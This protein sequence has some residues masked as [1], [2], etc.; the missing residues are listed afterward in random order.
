[1]RAVVVIG[2][3]LFAGCRGPRAPAPSERSAIGPPVALEVELGGCATIRG[4]GACVRS[5]SSA[6]SELR[7]WIRTRDTARLEVSL[8][9]AI[10]AVGPPER[11][12]GGRRLRI[13]APIEARQLSLVVRDG[14]RSARW[15]RRL[16]V[17]ASCP[18][19]D[20]AFDVGRRQRRPDEGFARLDAA[21]SRSDL[22]TGCRARAAGVRA[23]LFLDRDDPTSA[24]ASFRR[25]VELS[26]GES[27]DDAFAS[28]FVL[29][30]KVRDFE[31]A[32][33][34]LDA[35]E[36]R[37]GQ[38]ASGRVLHAYFRGLLARESGDLRSA[39][40][41]LSTS[42]AGA[43]RIGRT[44]TYLDA[45]QMSA[46]VLSSI[47]R[48]DEALDRLG[49]LDRLVADHPDVDDCAR[50]RLWA[51]VGWN[52]A[53]DRVARAA[54]G[55]PPGAD[56]GPPLRRSIAL[57]QGA[58]P[59]RA[60]QSNALVNLAVVAMIEGQLDAAEAALAR[61]RDVDPQPD[62]FVELWSRDLEG[63]I[64][65]GR[66]RHEEA[67]RVYAA[68][69]DDA[70]PRPRHGG[71]PTWAMPARSSGCRELPRRW[72]RTERPRISRRS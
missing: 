46:A 40:R 63:R 32:A 22:S 41:W 3:A 65:A 28:A 48:T 72:W 69:V 57:R 27:L 68:L 2:L 26:D 18:D 33:S 5:E 51:N 37:A 24:V 14:T 1:M 53:L 58:C 19:V 54:R 25:S 12:Q 31:A 43:E 44:R 13:E 70:P 35:V 52:R 9:D 59:D 17:R 21:L 55:A 62:D 50:A 56:P 61:A 34:A 38:A 15:S 8:D 42:A 45:T 67:R 71:A 10:V 23:R 16:A 60:M 30:Y 4:D 20:E 47:G 39:L 66:G 7:L 6:A 11:V 49:R 64:A 29:T 36:H